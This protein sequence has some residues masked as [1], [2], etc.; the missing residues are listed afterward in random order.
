MSRYLSWDKNTTPEANQQQLYILRAFLLSFFFPLSCALPY[1]YLWHKFQHFKLDFDDKVL[2]VLIFP[3]LF[4][5][6]APCE[7]ENVMHANCVQIR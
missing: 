1:I 5:T 3:A 4:A 6:A 7:V 2:F